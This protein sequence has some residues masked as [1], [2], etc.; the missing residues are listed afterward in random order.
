MSGVMWRSHT[1]NLNFDPKN[2]MKVIAFGQLSLYEKTG[3][4]QIYVENFE[5]VGIGSLQ[6]A[7]RQLSDKLQREGL[8][9]ER[10]KRPIPAFPATV[11]IITSP[12]GAAVHDIIRTIRGRNTA[13]KVVV[14]PA[15][16]QGED[17][18]ES[19]AQALAD[20]N[21][22]SGAD[23]IILGRGGGSIEDLWA[24]NEEILARAIFASKIPIISAVGHETDFTIADF[25]ADMRAAT[26]T[27]AAVEAVY[28]QRQV[29][30]YLQS[31]EAGLKTSL[32]HSMADRYG[33]VKFLLDQ[34]GRRAKDR[35]AREWQNLAHHEALLEKVSPYAAFKRGYALV[36][37]EDGAAVT[38]AK[39]V[40]PG[41]HLE[42]SWADGT[43]AVTIKDVNHA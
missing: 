24:F 7:F 11:A 41:Q 31:L 14:A 19:L 33:D 23:V 4:Y 27:A 5:P 3:Q 1:S 12:T 2:G 22:W 8:F 37:S 21:A 26:P 16:V 9:E 6:L 30:D 32:A 17:A 13:V 28:N 29:L 36:R 10:H 40:K 39:E 15:K 43:A 18:A 38:A 35:M 20:V 25:V 34:L 42:L